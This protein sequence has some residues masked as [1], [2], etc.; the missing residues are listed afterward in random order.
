[1][2]EPTT[3]RLRDA[4][5]AHGVDAP[6][7]YLWLLEHR[8]LGF[9]SF[10]QFE[11]WHFCGV[12]EIQPLSKRWPSAKLKQDLIPF[13]RFQGGDDIVCFEFVC[14]RVARIWHIHYQLGS[15]VYVE[16]HKEYS[17]IWGWLSAAIDEMTFWFELGEKQEK[18]MFKA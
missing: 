1:M 18:Q 4:F 14:G 10:T 5:R 7:E 13:A 11:P 8:T 15:P 2:K 3:D 17:T 12:E 6:P 16:F 9:D